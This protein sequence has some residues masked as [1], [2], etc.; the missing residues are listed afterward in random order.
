MHKCVSRIDWVDYFTVLGKYIDAEKT[1]LFEHTRDAF[2]P[3]AESGQFRLVRSGW[4]EG[5]D[6]N[7]L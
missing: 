6:D 7:I 1:G 2:A 5:R 3:I 4:V